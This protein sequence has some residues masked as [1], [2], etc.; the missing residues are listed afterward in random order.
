MS[1]YIVEKLSS[2]DKAGTNCV[3]MKNPQSTHVNI[4]TNLHLGTFK[5]LC[6]PTLKSNQIGMGTFARTWF[7]LTLGKSVYINT[8]DDE[9]IEPLNKITW[10]AKNINPKKNSYIEITDET[11]EQIKNELIGTV[12]IENLQFACYDSSLILTPIDLVSNTNNVINLDTKI[13]II[14]TDKTI[15]IDTTNDSKEL[16]KGNFNFLELGIG[17]LDKQFEIIFRR[18]FT[19]RLIP[20][21]VLENLGINHVKGIILHG[22]AGTGKTLIARQIGKILNCKEPKIINGPS[23]LSSY[24]GKSEENVRELFADAFADKKNKELHLIMFDEFD[25]LAKRRG[26]SGP[27]SSVADKIVNQ[28]LSMIDGPESL[29]NI[30]LIAMTNRL[31]MIDEAIL[32]PGR[33]EIQIEI[34]LPDVKGR[35]DILKIHTS[36]MDKAG[37]LKHVNLDEIAELSKNFTG[38][39]LESVV[40]NAVSYSISKVIDPSDLS[41]LNSIIPLITQ[42]ELLKSVKEIKPQFGSISKEIEIITSINFELYSQ[43]YS[44][45]YN[46][47]LEKIQNLTNGNLLTLLIKGDTFVG[48][49][50]LACMVAKNCGLNCIKFV[51]SETL[52]KTSS[53]FRENILYDIFEQG[54]KSESFVLILDSI[55][56]IIEYSKLGN[57]YNNKILQTIYTMM[58]KIIESNKKIV[59]ILTSSNET[60]MEITELNVQSTYEY[61]IFDEL[62]KDKYISQYFKDKKF[63]NNQ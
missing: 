51:N 43:N 20:N 23:L 40:K 13:N 35:L 46:E 1:E 62:I 12:P 30:L 25:S 44:K 58:S 50:T 37:Y 6:D 28:L 42:E 38:A 63:I 11:I 2:A 4:T 55:E 8:I 34:S 54:Y 17:G 48:K 52:M 36:K 14:S 61:N 39:E 16:F 45:S 22:P 53:M 33:F 9:Q 60:L 31:D 29:N 32:R 47:I 57:M 18:A 19:S 24:I 10:I 41:S 5:V 56:K 7:D 3:Y 26:G 49:T 15:H 27:D 21:K 59:I